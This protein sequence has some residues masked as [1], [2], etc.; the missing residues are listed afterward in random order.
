MQWSKETSFPDIESIN[1]HGAMLAHAGIIPQEKLKITWNG[2]ILNGNPIVLGQFKV[3][4]EQATT[5]AVGASSADA[6]VIG[7]V[8][9]RVWLLPSN[10]RWKRGERVHKSNFLIMAQSRLC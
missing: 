3:S 2:K 8:M 7:Q 1:V 10:H 5:R 9:K 4:T 6:A